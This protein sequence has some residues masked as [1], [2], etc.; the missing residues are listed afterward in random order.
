MIKIKKGLTKKLLVGF[1]VLLCVCLF[2]SYIYTEFIA[3]NTFT[4]SIA[5]LRINVSD[6]VLEIEGD[7]LTSADGFK[8]YT[9]KISENNLY[10]KPRY[11]IGGLSKFTIEIKGDIYKIDNVYIQGKEKNDIKQIWKRER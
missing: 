3:N 7:S 1:G 8:G 9:Y 10:V 6:S 11:F 5:I 2:I 4:S